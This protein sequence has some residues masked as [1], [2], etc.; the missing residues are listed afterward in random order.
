MKPL[1]NDP[2]KVTYR[3]YFL[4]PVTM[5]VREMHM[6]LPDSAVSQLSSGSAALCPEWRQMPQFGSM[7]AEMAASTVLATRMVVSFLITAPTVM[8]PGVVARINEC[9]LLHRGHSMLLNC[10]RNFLSLDASFDAMRVA[11]SHLWN[12][13]AKVGRI[14]SGMDG[15]STV[16]TFLQGSATY[17]MQVHTP[18]LRRQASRLRVEYHYGQLHDYALNQY[19]SVLANYKQIPRR[20]LD[21]VK[22]AGTKTVL[23]AQK[24][25]AEA[26]QFS[27]SASGYKIGMQF[28]QSPPSNVLK[29]LPGFCVG[30]SAFGGSLIDTTQFAWRF[31]MRLVVRLMSAGT[32]HTLAPVIWQALADSA[33]DYNTYLVKP[34]FR[35]CAGL[36]VMMGY[37]NPW[38][39]LF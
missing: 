14:L 17:N 38:A 29:R 28:F 33:D 39:R 3:T 32:G 19:K 36:G 22:T 24:M 12:S 9:V 4:H 2:Q 31:V 16:R 7:A 15:G 27:G 13:L 6:W 1:G 23:F 34:G 8:N 18:L 30:L 35:S 21:M 26:K 37:S 10:G 11:N 20:T 5:Q 25:L